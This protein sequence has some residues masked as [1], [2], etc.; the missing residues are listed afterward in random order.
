MH[1][2]QRKIVGSMV[3]TGHSVCKSELLVF[4]AQMTCL[5]V[6]YNNLLS[7]PVTQILE[8]LHSRSYS[9]TDGQ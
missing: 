5:L 3:N 9:E 4:V 1:P 7:S 8:A 6:E 2:W